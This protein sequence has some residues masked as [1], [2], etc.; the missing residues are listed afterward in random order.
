MPFDPALR[1][2]DARLY[3][4]EMI[5]K[6]FR[7]AGLALTD[8]VPIRCEPNYRRYALLRPLAERFLGIRVDEPAFAPGNCYF[9][10]FSSPYLET[11][12]DA[13]G[14]R[15]GDPRPK[16]PTCPPVP[17]RHPPEAPVPAEVAAPAEGE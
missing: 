1:L 5:E 16:P 3:C 10:T 14:R 9:G 15:H 11:V 6:A 13:G 2:D 17:Y 7:C 4:T 12:Y 8:P